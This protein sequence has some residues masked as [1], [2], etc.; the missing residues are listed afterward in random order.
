M[1][2]QQPLIQLLITFMGSFLNIVHRECS[3]TH[4]YDEFSF[5]FWKKN[6]LCYLLS[7]S[8]FFN[9]NAFIAIK[10]L[11]QIF[12]FDIAHS[13]ERNSDL[14]ILKKLHLIVLLFWLKIIEW[15]CFFAHCYRKV[16]ANQL[17]INLHFYSK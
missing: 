15:I 3:F 12:K 8:W 2:L 7:I 16:A 6:H 14:L 11:I 4:F 17:K 10:A 9:E 1:V 13:I 5:Y